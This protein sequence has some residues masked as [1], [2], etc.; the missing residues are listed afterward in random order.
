LEYEKVEMRHQIIQLEEAN[1][2]KGKINAGD[3][4]NPQAKKLLQVNEANSELEKRIEM[5]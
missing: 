2:P 1:D 3:M 5:L 4:K